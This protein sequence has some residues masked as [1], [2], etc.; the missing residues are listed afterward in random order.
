MST[1]RELHDE[2][3]RLA[4][5]AMVAHHQGSIEQA[6]ALRRQ[7]LSCETQAADLIPEGQASEPTRSVLYRS[8]ASL[9]YQCGDMAVAQRLIAKGLS[10]FPPAEIE[11]ELKALFEQVSFEH[12]L[13]E[14]DVVV[15]E[16]SLRL[17]LKGKAVGFGEI[18][19]DEFV[20]RIE[21][22]K[23]L[24]DRTWARM[25]QRPYQTAGR[26]AEKFRPF[27]PTLGLEPGS[28]VV[29]FRLGAQKGQQLPLFLTAT[30]V[31]NEV[32]AGVELM[33]AAD[34][35]ALH[36]HLS[37]PAYYRNFVSLVRDMAPD[38]ERIDIVEFACQ[39]RAVALRRQRRE[40]RL[41]SEVRE[42]ER[43]AEVTT[44]EGVLD[45]ASARRRKNTIGLTTD[46]GVEHNI[47]V[48]EGMEDLVRS[49]FKQQVTVTGYY[50]RHRKIIV[51]IDIQ[52]R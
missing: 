17:S 43:K 28:F 15:E 1:V 40:I 47:F 49:Y 42:T 38:G 19:Y 11:Q 6:Q 48:Q 45:F 23:T 24:L 27:V 12:Y 22:T 35:D 5:M 25:M 9:A 52:P 44:V 8:A 20:R 10:G 50:D 39:G 2:A 30:Q 31:I 21:R 7:A 26:I 16:A 3:V 33:N 46:D 41:V 29:T 51:P 13:A 4:Q 37:D 34:E 36:E 14:Q 18:L 32:I